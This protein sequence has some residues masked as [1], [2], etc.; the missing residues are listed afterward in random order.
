MSCYVDD[1]FRK[2]I[3]IVLQDKSRQRNEILPDCVPLN[4]TSRYVQ[5]ALYDLVAYRNKNCDPGV[6]N[7]LQHVLA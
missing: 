2:K 7:I 1:S 6:K 5:C 3:R 4:F